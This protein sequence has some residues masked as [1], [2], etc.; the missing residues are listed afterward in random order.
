YL[1]RDDMVTTV[2]ST[3]VSA[4]VHC[5]RCHDHKFDP[6]SQKDYYALQAVFAGVD[7]ADRAY[8]LDSQVTARRHELARQK[9][10]LQALRLTLVPLPTALLTS[11]LEQPLDRQLAA[12]PPLGVYGAANDFKADGSFK[13]AGK[14]RPIHVL[15]R[16]DIKRPGEEALPGALAC[17][18]GLEPRFRLADLNHEGSRRAALAHWLTDP[19]HV[20]TWR[21]IVNR[22]WHYHFGRGLVD[23]PNDFGRMGS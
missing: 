15:K 6:I 22:I 16:G 1:D 21:S 19:N 13:P 17:V 8:D 10:Q 12:Q 9:V 18:P 2:M 14:P 3:F 7:K 4:T 20:L 11:A 5:A 23:T